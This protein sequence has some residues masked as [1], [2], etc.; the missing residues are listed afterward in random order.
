M[1][2]YE[3]KYFRK[4]YDN[5]TLENNEILLSDEIIQKLKFQFYEWW[6]W[7]KIN[8]IE[9]F[10]LILEIILVFNEKLVIFNFISIFINYLYSQ[11]SI[12]KLLTIMIIKILVVLV[13]KNW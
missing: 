7:L 12:K 5:L 11:D 2:V 1:Y 9:K 10:L 4:I 6:K 3:I 13:F 8:L